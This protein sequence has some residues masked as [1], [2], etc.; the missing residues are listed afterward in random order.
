MF[1]LFK[2]SFAVKLKYKFSHG[3]DF[4]NTRA[5]NLPCK[6]KNITNEMN[7]IVPPICFYLIIVS[8]NSIF[9]KILKVTIRQELGFLTELSSE[10]TCPTWFEDN[11]S[12][13]TEKERKRKR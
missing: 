9:I 3:F 10:N 1:L 2:Q 11:P 8:I 7:E 13:Q 6:K 5:N 4:E 12:S